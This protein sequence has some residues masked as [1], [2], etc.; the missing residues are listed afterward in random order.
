[1]PRGLFSKELNFTERSPESQWTYICKGEIIKTCRDKKALNLFVKLHRKS[2]ED[3]QKLKLT[4]S[5]SKIKAPSGK[6][7]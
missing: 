1:M 2:C 3:C 6:L 4:L 7:L 5:D